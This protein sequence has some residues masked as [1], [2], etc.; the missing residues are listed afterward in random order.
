MVNN[1]LKRYAK[2]KAI[3]ED[4]AGIFRFTQPAGM[5]PSRY[6]KA[7]FAEAI[8]FGNVFDEGPLNDPF[9][10]E[11][12]KFIRNSLCHYSSTQPHTDLLV[13][14]FRAQLLLHI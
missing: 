1:L 6:G 14:A 7:L 10:E 9:I 11:M 2:D 3:A 12:N 13:L 4:D 8:F 5:K